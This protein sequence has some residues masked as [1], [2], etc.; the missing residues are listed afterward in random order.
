MYAVRIED[1]V[2]AYPIDLLANEGL[3]QDQIGARQVIVIAT[4]DGSGGR[5]YESGGLAFSL[6][7]LAAGTLVSD[8]GRGWR[9]TEAALVAEDGTE[10]ERLPGHNSF[11]FA[12][13][14]HA[15]NWRLYGDD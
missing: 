5:G 2:T 9:L 15:P 3:I 13:T 8:D 12:V 1:V 4:A 10:L 6:T 14:N 7:D 11:W